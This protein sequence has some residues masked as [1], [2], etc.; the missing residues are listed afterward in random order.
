MITCEHESLAKVNVDGQLEA[1]QSKE[2]RALMNGS[3]KKSL[4]CNPVKVVRSEHFFNTSH[5]EEI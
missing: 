4:E 2:E 5:N 1:M 3:A